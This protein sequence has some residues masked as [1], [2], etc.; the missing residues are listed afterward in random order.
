VL[1]RSVARRLVVPARS[2]A[3]R[4]AAAATQRRPLSR[5]GGR[6]AWRTASPRRRELPLQPTPSV[7]AFLAR[8]GEAYERK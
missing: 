1:S 3:R 6:A 8:T 2:V 4:L 5:R 7:R